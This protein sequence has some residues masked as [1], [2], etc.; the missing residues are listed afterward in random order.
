MRCSQ[1]RRCQRVRSRFFSREAAASGAPAHEKS[2]HAPKAAV[3]KE[4]KPWGIAR[5]AGAVRRTIDIA[6]TG[7]GM[8]NMSMSQKTSGRWVSADCG[9]VKPVD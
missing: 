7:G 8:G 1:K 9:A 4:Q 5:D 3:V 6:M 2:G